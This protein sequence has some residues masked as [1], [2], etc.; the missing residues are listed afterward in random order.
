MYYIIFEYKDEN[1]KWH[2]QEIYV[3]SEPSFD[4][5]TDEKWKKIYGRVFE[6]ELRIIKVEKVNDYIN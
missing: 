4:R 6:G 3:R 1:G 5:M 2:K